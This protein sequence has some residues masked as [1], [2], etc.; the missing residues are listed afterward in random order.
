[1]MNVFIRKCKKQADRFPTCSVPADVPAPITRTR[2][3]AYSGP[4]QHA[5][6]HAAS[7]SPLQNPRFSYFFNLPRFSRLSNLSAGFGLVGCRNVFLG[8]GLCFAKNG[9]A[10]V[11]AGRLWSG[12]AWFCGGCA[13]CVGHRERPPRAEL[14]PFSRIPGGFLGQARRRPRTLHSALSSVPVLQ[15]RVAPAWYAGSWTVDRPGHGPG[16]ADESRRLLR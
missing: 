2:A 5:P 8:C 10:D 7:P 13:G 12:L 16:H 14:G 3:S 11:L 9:F 15:V 4:C 1:M 6:S